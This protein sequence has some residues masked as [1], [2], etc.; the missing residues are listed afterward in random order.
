MTRL[1]SRSA[2]PFR[3]SL[4]VARG[5]VTWARLRGGEFTR[6]R[7]DTYVGAD[8]PDGVGVRVQGLA[9]WAGPGAV[10]AGPSAALAWEVECPWD[11]EEVVLGEV[12]RRGWG[13]V[14][15]RQD[16]LLTGEVT[17]CQQ[18]RVTTPRRT[19]FDLAR[20]TPLPDAVAA[21][22]ALAH[23]WR[24]GRAELAAVAAAH[25][26]A[27]RLVQVRAVLDLVE[28]LA[29]SLP[30][31]RLRVGL[32]QRGVPRPVAQYPVRLPSGRAARLDLAWPYPPPGRPPVA[33]EYDGEEHRSL[34]RHGRD[35]DRDAGLDDL[36]WDVVH[37][38]ARQLADLDA[39]A[40][41]VLRKL[42]C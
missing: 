13:G 36:G 38:T 23:A 27:R 14:T 7:P 12:H 30:E 8:V 3:G 35:L 20:R 24:F 16:L 42:G 32:M 28:P 15:V 2:D 25:P 1:T 22:D 33:L 31:S 4:A 34:A 17:W 40:A 41:R 19:A 39:L 26:R 9:V 18:A 37:V 21:V 10:V 6:L 11:D 29:E 5:D